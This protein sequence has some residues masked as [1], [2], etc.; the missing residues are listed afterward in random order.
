M[1]SNFRLN[2]F[3]ITVPKTFRIFAILDYLQVIELFIN[4]NLFPLPL[5]DFPDISNLKTFEE[6]LTGNFLVLRKNATT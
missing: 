3:A 2:A 1:N 6:K 4:E 5:S